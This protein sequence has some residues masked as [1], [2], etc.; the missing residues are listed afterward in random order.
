MSRRER[1]VKASSLS[2]TYSAG[3]FESDSDT[4]AI[5]QAKDTYNNSALGR[6]LKDIG[7][8]RFWIATED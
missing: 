8:F 3:R 1:L 2:A 6:Q 4:D 7:A 5:E